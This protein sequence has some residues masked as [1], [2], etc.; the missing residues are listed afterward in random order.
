M[1][2]LR[3]SCPSQ[4]GEK[5]G[6]RKM[7]HR[8]GYQ[9]FFGGAD[10]PF[11]PSDLYNLASDLFTFRVFA[12]PHFDRGAWAGPGPGSSSETHSIRD[13]DV[14]GQA[15]GRQAEERVGAFGPEQE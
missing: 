9:I 2:C 13:S 7:E 14:D 1:I 4:E 6:K 5:P 8:P 12:A 10:E 11:K 3:V 15:A